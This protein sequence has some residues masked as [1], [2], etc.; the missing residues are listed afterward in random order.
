MM[1]DPF[2]D[3]E[4]S[5]VERAWDDRGVR[6]FDHGGLRLAYDVIGDGLPVVL[7]CGAAGDSR[8]WREAGYVAGLADVQVVLLD[9]R[10]HGRS[11]APLGP[12]HRA[13]R[14]YV[15]DVVALADKLGLDRF[16][17]WGYSDG[18]RVG[19]ELAATYPGRV[20]ALVAAG[21]ADGPDEDPAESRDAAELVREQGIGAI[22]GDEPMPT[23]AV[24]QVVEETDRE[25]VARELECFAEWALWPLLPKIQTPTLVVAGE[26]EAEHINEVCG[27]L[28]DGRAVVIPSL[29]HIGAFLHSELVLPQVVPFLRSAA[30]A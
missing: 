21:A 11:A 13:V 17:F 23:W 18:A 15:G 26:L 20:V 25:V 1:S 29:G 2:R 24:R 16:V 7:H 27:A 10:G 9:P 8:M 4:A 3:A 22:I 30:R 5:G 12:G 14:H 6:Y 28:H 19:F